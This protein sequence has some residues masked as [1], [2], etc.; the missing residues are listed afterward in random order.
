MTSSSKDMGFF[1]FFSAHLQF[2][3]SHFSLVFKNDLWYTCR[4]PAAENTEYIVASR[5]VTS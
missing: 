3:S 2:V 1:S 5:V 4:K